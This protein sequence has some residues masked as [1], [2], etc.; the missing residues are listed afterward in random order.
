MS[1]RAQPSSQPER[2][3]PAQG[4]DLEDR[5][6]AQNLRQQLQQLPL[7]GRDADGRQSGRHARLECRLQ[8]WIGRE[9]AV[10]EILIDFSPLIFS[11]C[12]G[13]FEFYELT[14][15]LQRSSSITWRRRHA[16]T[17]SRDLPLQ[18]DGAGDGDRRPP[19]F[20]DHADAAVGAPRRHWAVSVGRRERSVVQRPRADRIAVNHP[21]VL[22][23]NSVQTKKKPPELLTTPPFEWAMIMAAPIS[24]PRSLMMYPQIRS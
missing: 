14:S 8:N 21:V 24:P 17:L 11:H 7:I 3:I 12:V 23:A 10:G 9:Q 16:L 4:S 6:S 19:Q 5:A 2:A 15:Q 22:S 18:R 1:P 13:K 20:R